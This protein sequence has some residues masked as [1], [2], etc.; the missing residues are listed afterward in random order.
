MAHLG[1]ISAAPRARLPASPKME[2][3]FGGCVSY[4]EALRA[5]DLVKTMTEG[6]PLPGFPSG[7][8]CKQVPDELAGY[9]SDFQAACGSLPGGS[10][11]SSAGEKFTRCFLSLL[12]YRAQITELMTRDV[13]LSE[14]ADLTVLSD[15]LVAKSANDDGAM[16]AVAERMLEVDPN[17]YPAAKAAIVARFKTIATDETAARSERNWEDLEAA[18]ARAKKFGE[19][20]EE[21]LE[22]EAALYLHH[23]DDL[24]QAEAVAKR[25]ETLHPTSGTGPYYRAWV[26]SKRGDMDTAKAQLAQ[27]LRLKPL[28]TRYQ[29]ALS[30]LSDDKSRDEAETAFELNLS[31]G[32]LD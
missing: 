17:F 4:W 24:V 27:A 23:G 10:T 22:A 3:R 30:S 12:D 21:L 32:A 16:L 28:D 31:F 13:P 1:T 26:A 8:N 14:I 6:Q 11:P 18:V 7:T 2:A 19:S 9:H 15:K 25:M 5:Q 29:R 20:D